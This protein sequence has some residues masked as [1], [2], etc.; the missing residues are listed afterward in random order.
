MFYNILY[1]ITTLQFLK[2]HSLLYSMWSS[3]SLSILCSNLSQSCST[4]RY[5]RRNMCS[6]SPEIS[7]NYESVL[8]VK[9]I[10]SV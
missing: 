6:L 2:R 10:Q 5:D 9:E 8:S 1:F 4:W 3:L 7:R